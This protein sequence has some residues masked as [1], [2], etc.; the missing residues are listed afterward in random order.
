MVVSMPLK[1][2]TFSIVSPSMSTRT[3]S[4][5]NS[6]NNNNTNNN[7]RYISDAVHGPW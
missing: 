2:L 1:D 5:V 7:K 4:F 3:D 6:D